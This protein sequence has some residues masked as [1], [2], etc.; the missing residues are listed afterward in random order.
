MSKV[1]GSSFDRAL[2]Y[3]LMCKQNLVMKPLERH[4]LEKHSALVTK[5]NYGK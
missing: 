1:K 5:I 4:H 2:T 3:H